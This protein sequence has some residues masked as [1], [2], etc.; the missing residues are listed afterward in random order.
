MISFLIDKIL[1]IGSINISPRVLLLTFSILA[2][3][4]GLFW[5]RHKIVASEEFKCLS[6]AQAK[7][8][9]DLKKSL[10]EAQQ[11]TAFLLNAQKKNDNFIQRQR[12]ALKDAKEQDGAV[13]DLLRG[14]FDRMRRDREDNP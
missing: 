13:S 12:K 9:E 3:A 5:F 14:T 2:I 7:E 8:N 6:G 11:Y 1:S 4:G 10:L